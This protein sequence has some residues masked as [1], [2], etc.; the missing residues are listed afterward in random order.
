MVDAGRLVTTLTPMS[1]EEATTFGIAEADRKQYVR[2][3]NGKVNIIRGGGNPKWFRLVRER[4]GNG[5]K[6]YPNGDE[7]QTVE[8]WQPPELW[9][10]LS[11]DLLNRALTQ[12]DAGT[13]RWQP[14][15]QRSE[16]W[17]ARRVARNHRPCPHKK[18][19]TGKGNN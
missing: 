3:D 5:T 11:V 13:C 16:S 14:L 6:L 1:S 12:I 8:P 4:L 17:R 7:V 18:R 19:G 9:S 10:N 2:L 15:H